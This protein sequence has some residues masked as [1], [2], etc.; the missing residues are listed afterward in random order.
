MSSLEGKCLEGWGCLVDDGVQDDPG[1]E[2]VGGWGMMWQDD[3]G[4]WIS[5][6]LQVT[7]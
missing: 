1:V 6:T 5:H 3:A 2:S 4:V 7:Q